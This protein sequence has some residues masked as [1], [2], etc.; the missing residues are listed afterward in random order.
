MWATRIVAAGAAMVINLGVANADPFQI[1]LPPLADAILNGNTSALDPVLVEAL[2]GDFSFAMGLSLGV[3]FAAEDVAL[4]ESFT[5]TIAIS[6]GAGSSNAQAVAE[7][8]ASPD[9]TRALAWVQAQA[10]RPLLPVSP[11]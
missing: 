2:R 7:V 10:S 3:A 6:R 5:R 8:F 1:E 11:D 9:M 4:A